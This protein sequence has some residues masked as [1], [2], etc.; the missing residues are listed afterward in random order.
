ML[1]DTKLLPN[2]SF[3]QPG[4]E[5]V[6]FSR[7]KKI[8]G[9]LL[10]YDI[11]EKPIIINQF[12][13][14]DSTS[15]FDIIRPKYPNK[16]IQPNWLRL[17]QCG[18]ILE[19]EVELSKAII[20]KLE[21]RIPPGPSYLELITE[22]YY[23]GYETYL[24]G[25]TVRDFLQGEKSNDIDLVT[26]MPLKS[27]IP[28]I[29]SMFNNKF[30]YH[31]ENGF[32]RI[33]GT[34]AS[35]DPFIDVKNFTL[36]NSGN[37][38]TLFGSEIEHDYKI[39][40]FACNAVYFDPI[41]NQ[42]IDPSGTGIEDS[43]NKILT[44]VKDL[45]VHHPY[46]QSAQILIRF[47]KFA[48]RGYSPTQETLE[49]IKTEYCPL[50]STMDAHSRMLYIKA[51][52]INKCPDDSKKEGYLLFVEKMKELGFEKEYIKYIKQFE[53]YLNLK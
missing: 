4:E 1:E 9:N 15:S 50:F 19:A 37:G 51:Q 18:L 35:G 28:L 3:P 40:D 13:I 5:V 12:Q 39:R 29:R 53:K 30:S 34:P 45:R 46:F 48:T 21:E 2:S 8:E 14:P 27:A 22:F 38:N 20:K 42:F 26:T 33:G 17:P 41:N 43:K 47:I 16:R 36:C 44:L 10:G 31:K 49:I 11:D 7:N 24:V 6:W 32:V 52:I 25:G 23:R